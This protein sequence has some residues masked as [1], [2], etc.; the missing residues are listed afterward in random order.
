M[1]FGFWLSYAQLVQFFDWGTLILAPAR[2]LEY[3]R[4]VLC[5]CNIC[6]RWQ[7]LK[8]KKKECFGLA[9]LEA[10]QK[11]PAWR[12]LATT[13]SLLRGAPLQRPNRR[14]SL[15]SPRAQSDDTRRHQGLEPVNGRCAARHCLV[16]PG[17]GRVTPRGM[18]AG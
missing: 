8:L 12:H 9:L 6:N 4:M 18:N 14:T 2:L 15:K 17:G 1:D 5:F 16:S 3:G 7:L 11:M 10:L 13:E